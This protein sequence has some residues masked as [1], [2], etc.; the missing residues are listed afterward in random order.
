MH[1]HLTHNLN[2]STK[3]NERDNFVKLHSENLKKKKINKNTEEKQ[4]NNIVDTKNKNYTLI[5]ALSA[6]VYLR[7]KWRKKARSIYLEIHRY[8]R[9]H[10]YTQV[11]TILL[12]YNRR[13]Q[14]FWEDERK[15]EEECD[16]LV[17]EKYWMFY[18]LAVFFYVYTRI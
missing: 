16:K 12:L 9:P 8:T 6:R 5:L 14:R 2:R 13:V 3:K 10:I 18:K 15:K 4:T 7:K 17:L 1:F 11:S